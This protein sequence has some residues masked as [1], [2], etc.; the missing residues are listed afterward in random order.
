MEPVRTTLQGACGCCNI[1]VV[2][3]DTQT[4][5]VCGCSDPYVTLRQGV[6]GLLWGGRI[7]FAVRLVKTATNCDLRKAISYCK[8]TMTDRESSTPSPVDELIRRKV[9]SGRAMHAVKFIREESGWGLKEAKEYVDLMY[10]DVTWGT[11]STS[12]AVR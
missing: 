1:A 3:K 4:C 5:P 9:K 11:P 12:S 10:P 6:K 8:R 7:L 2:Q